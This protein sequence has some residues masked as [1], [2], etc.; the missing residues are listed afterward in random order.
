[1]RTEFTVLVHY[2][3]SFRNERTDERASTVYFVGH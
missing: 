3:F 2:D 1:M